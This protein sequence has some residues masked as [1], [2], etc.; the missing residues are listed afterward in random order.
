MTGIQRSRSTGAG[1]NSATGSTGTVSCVELSM[2]SCAGP[3]QLIR[4]II[5]IYTVHPY[6]ELVTRVLPALRAR[7]LRS[8]DEDNPNRF[9]TRKTADWGSKTHG[10]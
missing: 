3:D 2:S 8:M 7:H 4:I 5:E 6:E 1:F 9:W 10:L